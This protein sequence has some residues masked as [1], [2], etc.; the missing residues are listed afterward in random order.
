MQPFNY[1]PLQQIKPPPQEVNKPAQC[2][3]ISRIMFEIVQNVDITC[4]D[5]K[6]LKRLKNNLKKRISKYVTQHIP[7]MS[8]NVKVNV[9]L[10]VKEI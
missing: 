9:F 8:D 6:S 1:T 7:E 2:Y 5:D 4:K 3:H 10:S